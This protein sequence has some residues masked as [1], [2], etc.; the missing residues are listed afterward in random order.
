MDDG[1]DL[2]SG[3]GVGWNN[4]KTGQKIGRNSMSAD[5]AWVLRGERRC[6]ATDGGKAAVGCQNNDGGYAGLEGAV[7]VCEALD[8]EH[9][10]L[11][12]GLA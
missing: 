7:E 2:W 12:L 11:L 5:E 3:V 6:C 9:V 1:A 8:I 4:E 10:Y